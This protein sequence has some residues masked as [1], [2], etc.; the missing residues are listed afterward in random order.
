MNESPDTLRQ[1]RFI[2]NPSAE[3]L[4]AHVEAWQADRGRMQDAGLVAF[5]MHASASAIQ[6]D[7]EKANAVSVAWVIEMAGRILLALAG[8]EK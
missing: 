3:L 4:E 5:Q 6:G 1:L 8:K 7:P 2:Q